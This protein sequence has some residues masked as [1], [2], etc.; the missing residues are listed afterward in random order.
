MPFNTI[1]NDCHKL[2]MC[3]NTLS[4]ADTLQK[5]SDPQRQQEQDANLET[6]A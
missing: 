3:L 6:S 5:V 2:A 1:W 4:P